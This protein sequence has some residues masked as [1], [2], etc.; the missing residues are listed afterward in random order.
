M[1]SEIKNKIALRPSEPATRGKPVEVTV[2]YVE[3]GKSFKYPTIHSYTFEVIKQQRKKAKGDDTGEKKANRE[4]AEAVFY[5]LLKQKSFGQNVFPVFN[6]NMIYSFNKLCDGKDNKKFDKIRIPPKDGAGRP[7]FF[8]AV[9]KYDSNKCETYQMAEYVKVN[10]NQRWG[11]DIQKNLLVLNAF[12][13]SDVRARYLTRGRNQIFPEANPRDRLFLPDGIELML[14]FH[15]SIRPGWDKLLINID[16]CVTTYY[17]SGLLID[18]IPKILTNK[19]T[20]DALRRGISENEIKHLKFCLKGLNFTTTYR[21][22]N[23]SKPKKKVSYITE[24]SAQQLKF[25]YYGRNI[26]VNEFFR[27][28]GTPLEFPMLPCVAV[29]S[30]KRGQND[31]YFP[32]EVCSLISG[33]KFDVDK[34]T[35]VQ[36]QDMIKKTAVKPSDRFQRIT[37]A[38]TNVYKHS[39]NN[40]MKSIG[41]VVGNELIKAISRVLEP[42]KIT[43][44][45]ENK[46]IVPESGSWNVPKFIAPAKLHSWS[47]VWFDP[48]L[49]KPLVADMIRILIEVLTEK[50]LNVQ[51]PQQFIQGNAQNC[52]NALALAAQRKNTEMDPQ[53]IVSIVSSKIN[54][55][56]GIYTEIKKACLV[57]LGINSQCFQSGERQWRQRWKPICNNVALKING[58]LGGTN[59]QLIPN[60][61]DFKNAKKYM[62]LG[63]DVFH[64]SKEEKKKGRP[65]IAAI[66]ASMDPYATKYVGRY[67][68]NK[69]LKNEVIEEIDS[70]IKDFIETFEEKNDKSLPEA[71]LFYRDGVAEGQFE[72]IMNDEVNKLLDALKDLYQSRE[73]SPP[74]LTF[75]IMQ[76]RHHTRAKPDDESNADPKSKGNC[77]PGTIIDKTIVVPQY[78][79]FL[80]QSHSSPLGTAR[81][82]YYHVIYDE[83]GFSQDEM[84]TLTYNLCFSSVRCNLALSMVTPLH[85]A[86]NLANLAKN[87]VTYEESP[88]DGDRP[89][90][91]LN[92]KVYYIHDKIKNA[93][94]FA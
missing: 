19:T 2:N 52:K 44:T 24:K 72:I 22:A 20:K 84:Q 13:N 48:D 73:L 59:S 39:E 36:R 42:P 68:M 64:P 3:I 16:T 60:Q 71:I 94:Y 17:P 30:T 61:L 62:I 80:L 33:E 58:K 92:G 15:Q 23:N 5:Q 9:L 40:A 70:M 76:K 50:G 87:F 4:E 49:N 21:S 69:K 18:L 43:S 1:S 11:E 14:G 57:D 12:I 35:K 29:K 46:E 83:I 45:P 85:Y 34:L 27:E 82:A 54:G 31:A 28:L 41:M 32:L 89:E 8:S 25:N 66:V 51:K 81:P 91:V 77:Q 56:S 78:F 37:N 53:L 88:V 86:H 63:A 38:L 75:V 79:T 26:S 74:K 67:S 10:T 93:M 90:D 6:A 7:K 65:S 55:V 47:V